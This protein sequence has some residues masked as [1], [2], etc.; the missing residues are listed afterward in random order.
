VGQFNLNEKQK[1]AV[2]YNEGDLLIIAGAGT[3][4]TSVLTKRIVNI[5]NKEWAKASEILALTFTE[6]ASNEM[7]ERIDDALTFGYE[8]VWVSTFHSFC[9]RI[10]RQ[11]GYHIGL[12]GEYSLM[13]TAQSYIFMRKHIFDLSL[14]IF[15]P[16]GNPTQFLND[17][18]KHFS[19]LQDED[20]SPD[21]YIEFAKNLPN[22]TVEEKET[23]KEVN[24]LAVVY[25]E[26]TELKVKSSKID[27]GDLIIFTLKL[28]REKPNVLE[29]YRSRFK[30]ILVDEFQDTNFT[31]NVLVNLLVLGSDMSSSVEKRP[32]LTVVG[33]DDQ[34][35]YKFRGAAISNIL[36][37]KHTYPDAKEVVLLEN[38]RSRQE[39]LD[40]AYDLIRHNNPNRLE[41]TENINKKLLAKGVFEEDND[42]VQFVTAFN[43]DREAEWVASEILKLT[44]HGDLSEDVP[45]TQQFDEEGQAT[46][47]DKVE[48][49]KDY[50]FSDI[51]ILVRANSHSEA[52]VQNLR[53]KGIP[54][55]LGGSRGLY[56]RDEIKNLIAFL[57]VLVDYSDEIS[58]YKLLSMDI[59]KLSPREYMETNRLARESH[60][61]LFEQFE[62]L[63]EIK[64]GEDDFTKEDLLEKESN[65]INKLFSKE[66]VVGISNFLLLLDYSIKKV[67]DGRSIGEILYDFIKDSGYIDSFLQE[68][69]TENLFAVSNIQKF[70]D[71]IKN[72]EKENPDSN[73]YE[74]VD[75]LNYCIEVGESPLVDQVDL[76]DVNA[77]NIL[78][79]HA[80]KGLEF[81]IVFLSNLV[82]ERFPSMNRS[83]VI[84][85]PEDLIKEEMPV[86]LDDKEAHIQEERR[87]FYVG[88]TRAKHR[89]YLTAANYYGNAK[90]RKKPSIF[91]YEILDRDISE[92]FLINEKGKDREF[93]VIHEED[94][95]SLL[96]DNLNV[97]LVKKISY[98]QIHVY[99][100]CPK[101]YEYAY[102][103]RVPQKPSSAM[104]FGSTVH[105]TLKS[106]YE[107]L[108]RS[109]E[110]LGIIKPPDEELLLE[111]YEKNWVG[112]GYDSSV[113]EKTRKET[114]VEIMKEFY[115]NLYN[116]NEN[117][118]MLEESFSVHLGDTVFSGKIDRMDLVRVGESGIPEVEIIDYKTGKVKN[119]SVIKND[120]QLPLYAIFAEEKLGVKVVGAKYIFVE[121]GEIIE[122][123]VSQKRREKSRDLIPGIVESISKRE[124]L[125]TPGWLCKFCDYNSVCKDAEL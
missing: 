87:L 54:Y 49:K 59:W 77:V 113:H 71:L 9:D 117:P 73:I 51:A 3:G 123:D 83:D 57:K 31:Q 53:Y 109:K 24:E 35:I 69:S 22:G 50:N 67:K 80:S 58:M 72:Y 93:E 8:E 39:I 110:G 100:D 64:L 124:F 105:N 95:H 36:Q 81:P 99:E 14:K 12:D 94:D 96:P 5:I 25:K 106:F 29:K 104:S 116:E 4:K 102:V 115:K 42:A 20:V 121:H 46:F 45:N 119:A 30:Y 90:R 68:E 74:Y 55:K 118:Y 86:K 47:I 76:E 107:E 21:Q 38:Y 32:M 92:E 43:D 65:L 7:Q 56:F 6:K 85:I 79:V 17:L 37:F 101:K 103:L 97:N 13:T 60:I 108:K 98:S 82:S 61:T 75:Y 122:V 78:T 88:A 10:L 120:L 15:R 28:L 16:L 91:L 23:F 41:V 125:A 66:S 52:I 18:L 1:E 48:D 27:F 84:P 44:G 63:W 70:F 111:L 11:D 19:R 40:K 33:D 34:A 114:G 62:N 89:L 26:Y 2:E 112:F